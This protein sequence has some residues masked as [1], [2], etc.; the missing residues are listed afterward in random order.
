MTDQQEILAEMRSTVNGVFDR[1][2]KERHDMK[3]EIEQL[4]NENTVLKATIEEK[5][6]ESKHLSEQLSAA[7]KTIEVLDPTG[8]GRRMV[9][10]AKLFQTEEIDKLTQKIVS[11][12][13]SKAEHLKLIELLQLAE[14]DKTNAN[15]DKAVNR[16]KRKRKAETSLEV[17]TDSNQK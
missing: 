17:E 12:E 8:T 13:K 15:N 4:K 11:L 2:E 1:M 6:S 9:D 14:F 10:H 5:E 7:L 3:T 16:A